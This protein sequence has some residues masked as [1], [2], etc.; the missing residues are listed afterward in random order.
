MRSRSGSSPFGS[1]EPSQN[2]Q[3]SHQNRH[4]RT[5]SIGPPAW[6]VP[7]V[8]RIRDRGTPPDKMPPGVRLPT[9]P[10]EGGDHRTVDSQSYSYFTRSV[11]SPLSASEETSLLGDWALWR[12]PQFAQL[13]PIPPGKSGRSLRRILCTIPRQLAAS[14]PDIPPGSPQSSVRLRSPRRWESTPCPM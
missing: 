6:P 7:G 3:E 12:R 1:W 14:A 5:Q 8:L 2:F 4:R 10:Q 11:N 13:G 9:P